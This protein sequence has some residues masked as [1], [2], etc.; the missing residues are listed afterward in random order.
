MNLH[1]QGPDYEAKLLQ[2]RAESISL[3]NSFI[4]VV[5][6][7]IKLGGEVSFEWPN[8]CSG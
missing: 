3:L 6:L 8:S 1:T 7:A 5:D 2:Q 4:E